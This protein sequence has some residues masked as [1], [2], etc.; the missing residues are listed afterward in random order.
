MEN[1]VLYVNTASLRHSSRRLTN[2]P[3][4]E[5]KVSIASLNF[6]QYEHTL[7]HLFGYAYALNR[8]VSELTCPLSAAPRT[9]R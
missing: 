4:E 9:S 5:I 7:S 8:M 3:N 6:L 1:R 2:A